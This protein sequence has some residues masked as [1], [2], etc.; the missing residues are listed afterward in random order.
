MLLNA[1]ANIAAVD[2]YYNTPLVGVTSWP[3]RL[4]DLHTDSK[5]ASNL[6]LWVCCSISRHT[7]IWSHSLLAHHL[8]AHRHRSPTLAHH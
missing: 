4:L 1:K 5:G 2:H 6:L 3:V 8:P 7:M